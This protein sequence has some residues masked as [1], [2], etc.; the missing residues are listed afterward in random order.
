MLKQHQTPI[1]G[2]PEKTCC[3]QTA[4]GQDMCQQLAQLTHSTIIKEVF[5]R[6][7]VPAV[8][9]QQRQRNVV[10][11][12]SPKPNPHL[13][14]PSSSRGGDFLTGFGVIIKI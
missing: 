13:S 10:T 1:D 9:D 4:D 14:L 12:Y 5:H 7:H 11:S 8:G 3:L 2:R 6:Q